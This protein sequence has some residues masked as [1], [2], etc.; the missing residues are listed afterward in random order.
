MPITS[1]KRCCY[2]D[3]L[4]IAPN[5]HPAL[6]AYRPLFGCFCVIRILYQ[7]IENSSTSTVEREGLSVEA[8]LEVA[9]T[10]SGR[11]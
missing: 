10:V 2:P 9:F 8:M 5:Y 1:E 3:N 6:P 7:R 11:A 4:P